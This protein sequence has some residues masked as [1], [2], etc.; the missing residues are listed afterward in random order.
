[1]QTSLNIAIFG[2]SFNPFHNGHLAILDTVKSALPFLNKVIIMPSY[3]SPLKQ[4]KAFNKAANQHRLNMLN[5]FVNTTKNYELSQ[6]EINQ[7]TTSY[8]IQTL[9]TLHAEQP[10]ANFHVIIGSDNFFQLHL[11]KDYQELLSMTKFIVINRKEITA[12]QYQDYLN[13]HIPAQY[14]NQFIYLTIAPIPISSS[15][16]REKIQTGQN[17]RQDVPSYIADYIYSKGLYQ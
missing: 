10:T 5:L 4:T 6:L 3:I 1:M 7:A 2:G 13:Q 15:S 9:Q 12:E 11:W 14:S 16:I 17:I 8:T